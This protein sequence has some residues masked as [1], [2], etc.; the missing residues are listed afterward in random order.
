M[1]LATF[2]SWLFMSDPV[3]ARFKSVDEGRLIER[4]CEPNRCDP[5]DVPE[6]PA[7]VCPDVKAICRRVKSE[8]NEQF[9]VTIVFLVSTGDRILDLA[10]QKV[11]E[12]VSPSKHS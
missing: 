11:D 9:E 1:T 7:P 8:A 6:K 5:Y 10:I 12:S 2:P 3:P 4:T